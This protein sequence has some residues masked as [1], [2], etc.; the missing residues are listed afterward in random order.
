MRVM[1]VDD[2]EQRLDMIECALRGAGHQIVA[3]HGTQDDLLAATREVRPEIVL[4]DVDSP[5]RDMLESLAQINLNDPMPVALFA[6]KSDVESIRR[7]MRAGVCAYVVDGL[8]TSRLQAVMEVAIA[9][10]AEHQALKRELDETKSRLNDRKDI[11][12]AKGLLMARRNLT[13]EQAYEQLR[14]A[15]MNRNL[16]IGDAARAVIAAAELL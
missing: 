2:D 3:R 8:S 9:R 13:E 16:K 4:I 7:A 12:R 10:F 6:A 1:L 14:K 11:D 5:G 15:A